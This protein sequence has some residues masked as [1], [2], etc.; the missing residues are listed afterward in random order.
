MYGFR[1][2]NLTP[3]NYL[4]LSSTQQGV[5]IQGPIKFHESQYVDD[6]AGVY[7]NSSFHAFEQ[8]NTKQAMGRISFY[9]FG[10]K[11]KYGHQ[12]HWVLLLGHGN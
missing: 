9:P 3:W 1:Y 5:S 7:N 12:V 10:A 8:T 2:V 6:D 4:S 11:W